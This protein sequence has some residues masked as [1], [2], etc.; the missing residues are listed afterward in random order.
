MK[1]TCMLGVAMLILALALAGCTG[2]AKDATEKTY[3]VKGKVI[4]V[5]AAKKKITLDHEEIPGLM[6]AM[7]MP[8]DL[9]DAKLLD[10]VKADDQVHGKLRVKDGKYVITE[11]MK[12]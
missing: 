5:D 2:P 10:G 7:K 3:E 9:D 11:W 6:K 8:F 4:A 12:H 1:R